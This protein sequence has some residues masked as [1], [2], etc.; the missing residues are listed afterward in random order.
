MRWTYLASQHRKSFVFKFSNIQRW[1]E[2]KCRR[3]W[4]T[5]QRSFVCIY[6]I[7]AWQPQKYYI[8]VSDNVI[9]T[10]HVLQENVEHEIF[11]LLFYINISNTEISLK[12]NGF[13]CEGNFLMKQFVCYC[14]KFSKFC[15]GN[16]QNSIV[17]FLIN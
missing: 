15:D 11:F 17:F 12:S 7:I 2:I 14:F 4:I 9:H 6:M 5:C 1:W 8:L 3:L 13:H 16:Y 10:P